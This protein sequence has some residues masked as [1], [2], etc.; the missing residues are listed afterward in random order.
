MSLE[1]LSTFSTFST[2]L[3]LDTTPCMYPFTMQ[4][5][6]LLLWMLALPRSQSA[7][8]KATFAAHVEGSRKDAVD[9]SRG[10]VSHSSLAF[11]KTQLHVLTFLRLLSPCLERVR[12]VRQKVQASSLELTSAIPF[13]ELYESASEHLSPT[14]AANLTP[15]S[16]FNPRRLHKECW[17]S[18][19]RW[20][21]AKKKSDKVFYGVATGVGGLTVVASSVAVGACSVSRA[22]SVRHCPD[23]PPSVAS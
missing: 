18:S 5:A 10:L 6:V 1:P 19:C 8:L 12:R 20:W 7:P 21:R 23:A 15:G 13:A 3:L 2:F 9:V 17:R 11:S 4:P 22:K 14:S 16:S